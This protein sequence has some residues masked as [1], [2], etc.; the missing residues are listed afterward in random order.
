[1]PPA[2]ERST[3]SRPASA[4]A[5]ARSPG[6]VW[7]LSKLNRRSSFLQEPA[8]TLFTQQSTP[9]VPSAIHRRPIGVRPGS[10]NTWIR[11]GSSPI[12]TTS[13]TRRTTFKSSTTP[14]EVG[15]V[16]DD[17]GLSTQKLCA[18]IILPIIMESRPPANS[19]IH[20]S[21]PCNFG[22]F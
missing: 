10:R 16:E 14:H 18:Q 22:G 19:E 7:L 17:A 13:A 11:K 2:F 12:S 20:N 21:C 5:R 1:M 15:R 9:R 6:C 4:L 3:E 8:W